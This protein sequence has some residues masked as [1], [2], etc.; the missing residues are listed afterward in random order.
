METNQ[1]KRVIDK[2][3]S[4]LQVDE[5]RMHAIL[6]KAKGGEKVKR[7]LPLGLLAALVVIALALTTTAATL[8]WEQ[9]VQNVKYAEQEKGYYQD[10]SIDEKEALI[11]NLMDM[12]YI[13][14]SGQAERL[15][16]PET[17][18]KEKHAVADQLMLALTGEKDV[19]EISAD[20]ITYSLL[21]PED[22][23]TSAQRVWWAG[24]INSV[25]DTSDDPDQLVLPLGHE[26]S[27]E[28]AIKIARAAIIKAFEMTPDALDKARPVAN[29]YITKA[30]PDYRRWDVQFKIYKE[31]TAD[32]VE[33]IYTAIV[34]E[35]GQVIAD[36]D[37]NMP[38]L[39]EMAASYKKLE[40]QKK[41]PKPPIIQAYRKYLEAENYAPFRN[42]C[43]ETKAAFSREV[44]PMVAEA[45]RNGELKEYFTEEGAVIAGSELRLNTVYAY[46][47]PGPEDIPQAEALEK[48]KLALQE[49][50]GVSRQTLEGAAE[51]AVY[52]DVTDPDK[53]LWKFFFGPN[54]KE[55]TEPRK[56]YRALMD[57]HNGEAVLT[58]AINWKEMKGD[59]LR[60]Y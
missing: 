36:P 34:D 1:I 13:D 27:E 57:A 11:K 29:L 18:E 31:G 45:E 60:R 37:V 25:R 54:W 24:V 23:W 20:I 8:L 6:S 16:D 26:V 39:E 21:G 58:E 52:F 47:L 22:T 44:R 12:G 42:W 19:R 49:N 5:I 56:A 35:K 9:Y 2:G 40:E 43:I 15:F 4:G 7:K 48:A 46:D 53:P 59:D 33:R 51:I 10:W 28:E 32:W 17:P 38:S 41:A 14:E 3:L 55:E 50:Y 30:R